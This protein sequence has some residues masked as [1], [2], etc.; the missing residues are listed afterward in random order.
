MKPDL[1]KTNICYFEGGTTEKF[2][3]TTL[4]IAREDR[5]KQSLGV[6]SSFRDIASLQFNLLRA[7]C[8]VL[9]SHNNEVSIMILQ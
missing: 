4:V 7:S 1:N 9:G 6:C 8:F 2:T 3:R 5:P